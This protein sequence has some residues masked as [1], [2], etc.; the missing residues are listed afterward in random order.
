MNTIIVI[1]LTTIAFP[2][3]LPF[4]E[5]VKREKEQIQFSI[6]RCEKAG[7]ETQFTVT[8]SL[9]FTYSFKDREI[10]YSRFFRTF[11]LR[12]IR[13]IKKKTI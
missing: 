12:C 1:F 5:A 7:P 10:S 11:D 13:F 2:F 3:N 8:P 4:V 9:S 6:E